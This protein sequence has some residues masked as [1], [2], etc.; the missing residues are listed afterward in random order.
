MKLTQS[1]KQVRIAE[2]CGWTWRKWGNAPSESWRFLSLAPPKGSMIAC[3][4]PSHGVPHNISELPDYF[5]DLNACH[6]AETICL[7]CDSDE[8]RD[9]YAELLQDAVYRESEKRAWFSATAG[10]RFEALGQTLELWEAGE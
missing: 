8:L 6:E 5:N 9:K 7:P 1:Q 10:Q 2:A 4:K 3:D